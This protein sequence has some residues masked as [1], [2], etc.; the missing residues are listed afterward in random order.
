MGIEI[1]AQTDS[2]VKNIRAR[3][4]MKQQI[5]VLKKESAASISTIS[6]EI[7]EIKD[8]VQTNLESQ[9]NLDDIQENIEERLNKQDAKL[10]KILKLLG[11]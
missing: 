6:P 11:E 2:Q 8:I 7:S 3:Q 9:T 4:E 1:E 5:K 10:D